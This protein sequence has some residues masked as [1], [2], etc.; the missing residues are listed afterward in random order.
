MLRN[1]QS[2][3]VWQ[4]RLVFFLIFGGGL[5]LL[6]AI[7]LLL[8]SQSLNSGQR[9]VSV[10]LV[11]DV[12]VRPFAAL[13]GDDAYP[14]AVAVASDGTVYTGSFATGAVWTITPQGDA[15]EIPGTRDAI[16][17]VM[18]LAVMP[19]GT[20]LVVDQVDTDPL[21]AGGQVV[22]V[23]DDEITVF[24]DV[25]FVAPN[26]LAI[27]AQ[28]RVYVSDSGTNQVWRFDADG[29]NGTIWWVSPVQGDV[30]PAV[31]G[32]A[33]DP[34]SDAIIVTD[35][36]LNDVYRVPVA[37]TAVSEVIYHHG[38]RS[39]PPGFDGVTVTPDG[40]IYV[41]ALGQNGVA[42]VDDG[43]LDYI[44][45]LFRGSSDVEFGAP[46]RLYV[47]NFDQAAIVIPVVRP[48]LP[49]ALDV[50]EFVS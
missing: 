16:G 14:S 6:L 47:T 40:A 12:T 38:D 19:D 32:L 35:P 5:L 8:V 46:N 3:S 30:Q 41:A 17:A 34:V 4:R 50:I 45:G 25:G 29:A 13:P 11:P 42:R 37:D 27:D 18:G 9:V 33:Y 2:M 7:T 22:R 48:Q 24:A 49:F 44:A 39:N 1:L 31:T 36:E 26:D 43:R 28:G 20:L 23:R 15:H 21:S 10:A